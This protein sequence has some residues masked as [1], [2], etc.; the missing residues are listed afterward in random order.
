MYP[1]IVRSLL[2]ELRARFAFLFATGLLRVAHQK[3]RERL[4]ANAR[5]FT[6]ELQ[7]HSIGEFVGAIPALA[8]I[9]V[10]AIT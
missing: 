5:L 3:P 1:V 7:I 8:V 10:R 4:H 6:R 9:R 2:A